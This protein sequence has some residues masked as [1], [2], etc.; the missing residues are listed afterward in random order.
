MFSIQTL[1]S[2]TGSV[3]SKSQ[4]NLNCQTT[5]RV[6]H[7]TDCTRASEIPINSSHLEIQTVALKFS[8]F[9]VHYHSYDYHLQ[10][11]RRQPRGTPPLGFDILRGFIKN[12]IEY[13]RIQRYGAHEF[14][15][16]Y[17]SI[18]IYSWH[19]YTYTRTARTCIRTSIIYVSTYIY[20]CMVCIYAYLV[21]NP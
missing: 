4:R 17:Q 6:R 12:F 18:Q 20:I 2:I 14:E 3:V 21:T 16:S 13:T 19:T 9:L 15:I 10:H 1:I 5:H 7:T 8:N 11:H